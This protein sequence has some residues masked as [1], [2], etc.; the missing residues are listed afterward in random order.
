VE[1]KPIGETRRWPIL[2]G[3]PGQTSEQERLKI[4]AGSGSGDAQHRLKQ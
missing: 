3:R 2:A 4:E 1:D